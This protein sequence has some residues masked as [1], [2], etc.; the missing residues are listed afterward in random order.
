MNQRLFILAHDAA[1]PTVRQYQPYWQK[2]DPNWKMLLPKESET[3]GSNVILC[4]KSAYS[5]LPILERFWV[6]LC[7]IEKH[8]NRM[9]EMIII[10]EYDTIPINPRPPTFDSRGIN[11]ACVLLLNPDGTRPP[12][13]QL[14]MLSP[15]VVSPAMLQAFKFVCN[16]DFY[17]PAPWTMGL[18]DRML[19]D[20]CFKY[21]LQ[22]FDIKNAVGWA[23]DEDFLKA[24]AAKNADW[25]HG[26]KSLQQ[27]NLI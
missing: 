9:D 8:I 6:S 12:E 23:K 19:G 10:A 16:P 18:L 26:A 11:S 15:W 4:G 2:I 1:M 14:C 27:L 20:A 5:G 21:G 7:E 22:F 3:S 13:P 17:T 25:I 24:A